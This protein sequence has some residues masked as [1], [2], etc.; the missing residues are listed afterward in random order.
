MALSELKS[1][2]S[3]I[4]DPSKPVPG[5]DAAQKER[6]TIEYG[7]HLEWTCK[8]CESSPR[9]PYGRSGVLA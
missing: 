5:C 3:E 7:E 4:S 8:N 6:C 9:P 1:A 2:I